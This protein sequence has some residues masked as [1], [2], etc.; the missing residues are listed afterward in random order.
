VAARAAASRDSINLVDEENPG[1]CRS[2][3][4]LRIAAV[5]APRVPSRWPIG[6][7]LWPG[8]ARA[9]LHRRFATPPSR[10]CFV[11]YGRCHCRHLRFAWRRP[12]R[13]GSDRLCSLPGRLHRRPLR[14]ADRTLSCCSRDGTGHLFWVVHLASW[15]VSVI[16]CSHEDQEARDHLRRQE[17]WAPRCAIKAD[18]SQAREE[19]RETS[20][21]TH[22]PNRPLPKG[23]IVFYQRG[24]K[25]LASNWGAVSDRS[26]GGA[27]CRTYL[28]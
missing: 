18:E 15:C 17:S 5:T 21:C 14:D 8:V 12:K 4:V 16:R 26:R 10:I 2:A 25:K 24:Q 6:Q 13:P 7:R 3:K 9:R 1:A 23:G 11:S 28:L 22:A 27:K 19:T 20:C